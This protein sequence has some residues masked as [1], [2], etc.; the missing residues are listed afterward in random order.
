MLGGTAC[1]AWVKHFDMSVRAEVMRLQLVL[2]GLA[3]LLVHFNERGARVLP[4]F[5]SADSTIIVR[6]RATTHK[7]VLDV[8]VLNLSTR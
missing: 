5:L 2:L 8:K 4:L 6:N 1:C 7:V 3:L